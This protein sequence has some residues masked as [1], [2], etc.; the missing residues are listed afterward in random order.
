MPCFRSV[1][2]QTHLN[3]EAARQ[4]DV[5]DVFFWRGH[6]GEVLKVVSIDILSD[7]AP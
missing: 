3:V 6:E 5:G 2:F 7:C 1:P 4:L